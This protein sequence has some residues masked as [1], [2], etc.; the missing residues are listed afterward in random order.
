MHL[1]AQLVPDDREVPE[2][3][4]D[5]PLAKRRV[6]GQR[7]AQDGRQQQQQGEERE[8]A[9]I[10]HQ[11]GIAPCLVV[12][13]FLNHGPRKRE[14]CMALLEAVGAPGLPLG[15][16]NLSHF[17]TCPIAFAPPHAPPGGGPRRH[18]RWAIA[19]AACYYHLARVRPR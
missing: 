2:R 7:K 17:R 11:R 3:G 1:R 16:A 4:A 5:Q 15:P 14:H 13:E 8:Q 6:P 12:A 18:L 19:A 9:V 10:G